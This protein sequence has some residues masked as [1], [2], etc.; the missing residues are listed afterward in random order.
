MK[1]FIPNTQTINQD[2]RYFIKD[3]KFIKLDSNINR[4]LNEAN[5]LKNLEH[6]YIQK[7]INSYCENGVH[8]LET[9]LFKGETLENSRIEKNQK[10]IISEQ[11][12]SVYHY[13]RSKQIVHGDINVSNVL[14]DN[15]NILIIDWETSRQEDSSHDLDGH[16]W[17][18]LDLIKKM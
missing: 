7:Y 4:G 9:E 5:T 14:F 11:L 18:I 15:K 3:D 16:P 8:V 17:G 1:I 12:Y 10:D 13:L 6:K 2:R